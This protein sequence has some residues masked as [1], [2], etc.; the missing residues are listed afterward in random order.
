MEGAPCSRGSA[1]E[2]AETRRCWR[3]PEDVGFPTDCSLSCI[4]ADGEGEQGSLALHPV[5]SRGRGGALLSETPPA[6]EDR[7]SPGGCQA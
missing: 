1:R 3:V 6:S 7:D 5:S 4:E 2:G